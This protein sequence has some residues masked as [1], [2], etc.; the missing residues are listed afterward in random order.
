MN[1]TNV[2]EGG[3]G[4][5]GGNGGNGG[6]GEA[7]KLYTCE[8]CQ[9]TFSRPVHLERHMRNV[10]SQERESECNLCHKLFQNKHYL[11]V[12]MLTHNM[13]K[14][15]QC[16]LCKVT[17]NNVAALNKHKDAHLG[18]GLLQATKDNP[19]NAL[20][21]KQSR[22]VASLLSSNQ[23]NRS[24]SSNAP[25]LSV[26]AS[27]AAA[28]NNS[29]TLNCDLRSTDLRSMNKNQRS[30]MPNQASL[31]NSSVRLAAPN[32]SSSSRTVN[33][34]LTLRDIN[35]LNT[36]N[37]AN[38]RLASKRPSNSDND[39]IVTGVSS[40]KRPRFQNLSNSTAA[41]SR[42]QNRNALSKA[43]AMA[44]LSQKLA[45]QN[46]SRNAQ[47]R[48]QVQVQ[49]LPVRQNPAQNPSSRNVTDRIYLMPENGNKR[50]IVRVYPPS[51]FRHGQ[52]KQLAQQPI[53]NQRY[54]TGNLYPNAGNQQGP[55][56][57]VNC[58]LT[59]S[60]LATISQQS[61]AVVSVPNMAQQF[62]NNNN[63]RSNSTVNCDL[64][65][66]NISSLNRNYRPNN[67][68]NN[69]SNINSNNNL[70]TVRSRNS[71][72]LNNL[73]LN[74]SRNS[75]NFDLTTTDI[76]FLRRNR[77]IRQIGRSTEVGAPVTSQSSNTL[78]CDLS[79][80]NLGAMERKKILPSNNNRINRI[81]LN[82]I[83]RQT[84][85]PVNIGVRA[86]NLNQWNKRNTIMYQQKTNNQ[87]VQNANSCIGNTLNC[88]LTNVNL[89]TLNR[90][91]ATNNNNNNNNIVDQQVRP[92]QIYANSNVPLNSLVRKDLAVSRGN[93]FPS[94]TT[95]TS[96][97]PVQVI[98]NRSSLQKRAAHINPA[99]STLNQ[100]N[101]MLLSRLNRQRKILATPNNIPV[102]D[103]VADE[104]TTTTTTTNSSGSA[105]V[106]QFDLTNPGVN[107][108]SYDNG[109]NVSGGKPSSKNVIDIV[110]LESQNTGRPSVLNNRSSVV[111]FDLSNNNIRS[112][113]MNPNN[114]PNRRTINMNRRSW[115][116]PNSARNQNLNVKS[117]AAAAT[118]AVDCEDNSSSLA[119][120]TLV[121]IRSLKSPE[122]TTTVHRSDEEVGDKS[123]ASG[124]TL[125]DIRSLSS[126]EIE[127]NFQ[128]SRK[129]PLTITDSSS[130]QLSH[131]LVRTEK[132]TDNY[133]LTEDCSV[134]MVDS[135]SQASSTKAILT[136][137]LSSIDS[138]DVSVE[139]SKE[140][141]SN[142][143]IP[144]N[145]AED[146]F[147]CK[148]CSLKSR[149]LYNYI[150]HLKSHMETDFCICYYCSSVFEDFRKLVV[151]F[152]SHVG[153]LKDQCVFCRNVLISSTNP[154]QHMT[155]CGEFQ[156]V[157]FEAGS[158][159]KTEKSEKKGDGDVDGVGVATNHKK[160]VGNLEERLLEEVEKQAQ[161]IL[162]GQSAE[163]NDED[164]GGGGRDG[165]GGGGGDN[166]NDNDRGDGGGG[167][168]GDDGGETVGDA[169]KDEEVEE[170]GRK[171]PDTEEAC[172]DNVEGDTVRGG[173]GDTQEERGEEEEE[174]AVGRWKGGDDDENNKLLDDGNGESR[175]EKTGGGGGGEEEEEEKEVKK[176]E[177][178]E[179]EDEENLFNR[180][181][182]LISELNQ[183]SL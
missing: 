35:S 165:D 47:L 99:A 93:S 157:M 134:T 87:V 114:I 133:P 146:Q 10:H 152:V 173:G 167:V 170:E 155:E 64:T 124:I 79:V 9:M 102:I 42:Q 15:L 57:V 100:P 158:N 81:N 120:I 52:R 128:T 127:A 74:R 11:S 138:E 91:Q 141:K 33:C 135:P 83:P 50:N 104:D 53:P 92:V 132:V 40:L 69:N 140:T 21:A 149:H 106:V 122:V 182:Q 115:P 72:S 73:P 6:N 1:A 26:A 119:D 20:A 19:N 44:M 66:S 105:D 101:S 139:K 150:F 123:S 143:S 84:Q 39:V 76:N 97:Y 31:S 22:T 8:H 171:M 125:V 59:R 3:G 54:S 130:S 96:S 55:R 61:G 145:K 89:S 153:D 65:I 78:N 46:N 82:Q 121:D 110:D 148:H 12:H 68:N 2:E 107:I 164:D 95:G 34:D 56:N 118:V 29:N 137:D 129:E 175:E 16:P 60:D 43:A 86:N 32:N 109:R 172:T 5:G 38:V 23:S 67:N 4:G 28:N 136:V 177:E 163:K 18:I 126:A 169:G 48:N 27:A 7:G 144:G 70:P 94:T 45:S 161:I 111:E 103:L 113:N 71:L 178:E 75:V 24:N 147:T 25:L 183:D 168:G 51:N 62:P 160:D 174:A 154:I 98:R 112:L 90:H 80:V 159:V 77:R 58:D 108:I 63:N 166:D 14:E 49:S 116:A 30:L 85:N 88:D 142:E 37:E 179:E 13:P 181:D 117:A 36:T 180:T 17:F 156:C 151:H 41:Q 176:E 131:S 162:Q